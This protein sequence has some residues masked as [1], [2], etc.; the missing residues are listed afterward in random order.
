MVQDPSK[1]PHAVYAEKEDSE[2]QS[3]AKAKS[4]KSLVS[5]GKAKLEDPL[6]GKE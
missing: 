1:N 4:A 5:V 3:K 2:G 6:E